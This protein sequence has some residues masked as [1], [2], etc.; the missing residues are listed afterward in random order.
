M[1][2]NMRSPLYSLAPR[3]LDAELVKIEVDHYTGDPG[4]VIVGLPDTAVQES[5][6]RV[7]AAIKNSDLLFPRGKVVI[8]LAPANIRKTGPSF[9]LPIALALISESYDFAF[10]ELDRALFFGELALDGAVRHVNGIL[11]LVTTARSMGYRKVFVPSLN[12]EEASLIPDIEV[13]PVDTLRQI[14]D[15]LCGQQ[16]LSSTLGGT[17]PLHFSTA[18]KSE[19]D[20]SEI[21]GQTHAKRA[22]EIAA[23]GSHNILLNG[24]PGSGKTMMARALQ[25]IMPPM[26]IDECLEVTKIYSLAGLLPE[27]DFIIRR[28]PFRMV[29]HTASGASII[30]GGA[31]PKPG[32]ISLS[33]RGV[34]FLD[35]MAEFPNKVLEQLRQPLEDKN[36]TIT[37]VQGSI[38]YP[39]QFVLCGAMNPCPCGF[40]GVPKSRKICLCPALAV[41]RY[42]SRI[43]GPLLDRI[44]LYCTVS[45]VQHE[46]L[47][48]VSSEEPSVSVLERVSQARAI[49]VKRFVGTSLT[50]NS[51]M[52]AKDIQKFCEISAGVSK[53]LESAM[54]RLNLSAR[55]YHRVLKVSRTIADLKGDERIEEQH[56]LEALQFR[57]VEG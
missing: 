9:D 34:L 46:D 24:A 10:Q 12:A 49:Q 8:N 38:S 4:I 42:Q 35:E 41:S 45:P 11:S 53:I 26:S 20:F 16:Q 13:F 56:V 1:C 51:E 28:R 32:E 52:S 17:T 6:E 57:K 15:F 39:A 30:G 27:K 14:V 40:H 7:K 43:S 55:G 3:G 21:R 19:V 54:E 23:A 29:H 5:K 31:S 44:D 48:G 2:Q 25:G 37:R 36:I 18:A 22:L 47:R 50:V 33:H